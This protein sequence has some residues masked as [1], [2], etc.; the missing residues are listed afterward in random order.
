MY[1][2]ILAEG[3][4]NSVVVEHQQQQQNLSVSTGIINTQTN[5]PLNGVQATRSFHS[6]SSGDSSAEMSK[7][8][9]DAQTPTSTPFR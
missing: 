7:Y 9:P 6:I 3:A 4:V 5:Q 1:L 8:F 2:Y